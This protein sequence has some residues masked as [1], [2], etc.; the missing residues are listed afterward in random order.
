MN[1]QQFQ[2]GK[3]CC[4][5]VSSSVTLIF[6]KT[7]SKEMLATIMQ[8]GSFSEVEIHTK[9]GILY[10]ENKALVAQGAFGRN[11]LQVR[12]KFGAARMEECKQQIAA[13]IE[14]LKGT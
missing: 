9:A 6:D 2:N 10:V 13:F 8:G 7:V 12:C 14:I 3:P 11:R 1:I 4:G 5:G